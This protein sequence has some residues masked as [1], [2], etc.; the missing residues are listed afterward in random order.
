MAGKVNLSCGGLASTHMD[1]LLPGACGL[2][3]CKGLVL[4]HSSGSLEAHRAFHACSTAWP[5]R[6]VMKIHSGSIS[7]PCVL[8]LQ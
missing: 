5:S 3:I 6:C 4:T 2:D 8:K 7:N 1:E